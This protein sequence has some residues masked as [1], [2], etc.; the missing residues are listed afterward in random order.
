MAVEK[1]KYTSQEFWEFIQLPQNAEKSF[2]R[3]N[4]EIF[5][6]VPSN[7]F[8]SKIAGLI[9]TEF[10]IFLKGKDLGHVTGA[11]GGYDITNEDTFAPDVAFILKSRQE[12]LPQEGFNPIPPDLAVE[13][14]SPS[15]LK[16]P[17]NRIHKKIEKYR[18]AKVPLLWY[19]YFDRKEVD[20]YVRGVLVRTV[21]IEGTLDGGD[22]LPGFT[23]AVK[24][25]F[26]E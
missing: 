21:G 10:N 4:G 26:P 25:I 23:L 22:I 13:V 7:P 15:D 6:V 8:S 1:V 17:Q 19:A 20:V 24:D 12:K 14:V 9:L 5:E 2:E 3:I 18:K 16:D 11:D